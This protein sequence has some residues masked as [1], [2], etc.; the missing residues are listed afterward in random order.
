MV[1]RKRK[2]ALPKPRPITTIEMELAIANK[3]GVRTNIIVPNISWG[4]SG[5]HECDVFII[6]SSGYCVEVEIKRSKSDLLADFKKGHNHK[7]RRNR[8][9]EFYYCFP[10][11]MLKAFEPLIPK[12]AGIITCKRYSNGVFASFYREPALNRIAVK[13]SHEEQFKVARLG[14]MRIWSLK[15]KIIKLQNEKPKG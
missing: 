15:K 14:T 11:T 9:K 7:D 1:T 3:F 8:I 13:L 4:L 10:E 12:E 2:T 6:K 5:M